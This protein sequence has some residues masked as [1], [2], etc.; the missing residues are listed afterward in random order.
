MLRN[1]IN[2]KFLHTSFHVETPQGWAKNIY[3]SLKEVGFKKV[4]PSCIYFFEF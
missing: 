2:L 1:E 4:Y 3:V